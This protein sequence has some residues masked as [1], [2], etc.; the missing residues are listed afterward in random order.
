MTTS[1]SF[2]CITFHFFSTKLATNSS[3][4]PSHYFPTTFIFIE[5]FSFCLLYDFVLLFMHPSFLH[6][7][8]SSTLKDDLSFI[9]FLSTLGNNRK[10]FATI[11]MNLVV[12]TLALGSQTKQRLVWVQAK[13]E[14]HESHLMLL[15]V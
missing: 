11:F 15:R 13:K 1:I 8:L 2:A 12:A 3:F 9:F 5:K 14:A 4:L 6:I 10:T 7:W